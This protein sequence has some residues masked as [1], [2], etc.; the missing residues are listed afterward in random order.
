MSLRFVSAG[1]QVTEFSNIGIYVKYGKYNKFEV[2]SESPYHLHLICPDRQLYIHGNTLN[3]SGNPLIKMNNLNGFDEYVDLNIMGKD[4]ADSFVKQYMINFVDS[5]SESNNV[6]R[7][8]KSG[9]TIF[10]DSGGFQIAMG[11]ATIINPIDLVKFYNDN[12]DLGMVLDIPDYNDGNPFPDEMVSELALI[13]KRNNEYMLK[14]KNDK[15]E[16]I[17]I[18]HGSTVK[19]KIDYLKA[20]HN[21]NINRLAL[22]S[23]GIPISLRRLNLILELCKNA[24]KLGHYKHFHVLGSFNK[25]VIFVLAKLAHC[26]IPEV[27]GIEFT[28]D[29]SSPLQ[30]AVNFTYCKNLNIWEGLHEFAPLPHKRLE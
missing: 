19:Q 9:S 11:R 10:C 24:K 29:A 22:P 3:E 18:I 27:E 2:V 7:K 8:H 16:L 12:V 23:V 28:M 15:V 17:N 26:K 13:Q 14:Y 30:T 4:Y 25:G 6:C 1:Y 20:V 5:G 21:E